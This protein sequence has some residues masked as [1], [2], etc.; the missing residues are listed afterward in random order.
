MKWICRLPAL[1]LQHCGR[2]VRSATLQ[3]SSPTCLRGFRVPVWDALALCKV[4][5]KGMAC[6][7]ADRTLLFS[8]NQ[9]R[10]SAAHEHLVCMYT[11]SA[12]TWAVP[13]VTWQ[14]IGSQICACAYT[15][16]RSWAWLC[17]W[18]CALTCVYMCIY[19]CICACMCVS[20]CVSASD[21][22]LKTL[23]MSSGVNTSKLVRGVRRQV[24]IWG[25]RGLSG[26]D[27]P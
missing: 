25:S 14:I 9:A 5:A 16:L 4:N 2:L 20:I 10:A 22:F 26:Q 15:F 27:F 23:S 3:P 21:S 18:E 1:L 6:N 11:Y 13:R 19:M 12:C 24:E 7:Q 17:V 8:R